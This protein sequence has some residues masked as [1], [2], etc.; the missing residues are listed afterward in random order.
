VGR[1]H[2]GRGRT[3]EVSILEVEA[4]QL[5]AGL[6]GIHYVLIDNKRSSFGVVGDAL[7]DLTMELV[8]TSF[9]AM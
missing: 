3:N 9:C 7:A 2:E 5:V 8:S 4:I 1:H 6:L